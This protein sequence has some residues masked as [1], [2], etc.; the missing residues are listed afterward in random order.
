[1]EAGGLP[2]RRLLDR[3]A[4]P[5]ESQLPR[6]DSA[7]PGVASLQIL[8]LTD[9]CV[10]VGVLKALTGPKVKDLKVEKEPKV[11]KIL[12]A[13]PINTLLE[14]DFWTSDLERLEC[15]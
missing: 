1:V 4:R 7:V 12:K 2:E 10:G 15:L 9:R 8:G 6:A 13:E 3:S 14:N 5:D 11:L